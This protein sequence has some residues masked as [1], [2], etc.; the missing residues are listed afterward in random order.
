MHSFQS[1]RGVARAS[2]VPRIWQWQREE[3]FCNVKAGLLSFFSGSVQKGGRGDFTPSVGHDE[4][5]NLSKCPDGSQMRVKDKYVD[6][7]GGGP[8]SKQI[9]IKKAKHSFL[10]AKNVEALKRCQMCPPSARMLLL[11]AGLV[12]LLPAG[13]ML[14]LPAGREGGREEYMKQISDHAAQM[15]TNV[16]ETSQ[17]DSIVS[18]L[19]HCIC[20]YF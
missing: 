10:P 5:L 8:S 20:T 3:Q 17:L 4:G 15:D 19:C 6:A 7:G 13:L 2:F 12:L 1:L 14:L 16:S 11:P 18:T 9:A